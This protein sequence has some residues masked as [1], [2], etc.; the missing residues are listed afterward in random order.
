MEKVV[1]FYGTWLKSQQDFLDTC[2]RCQ[3]EL[4]ENWLKG[5]SNIQMLSLGM[6]TSQGLSQQ[7]SDFYNSWVSMMTN[8]SKI[9]TEGITNFQKTLKTMT[10]KQVEMSKKTS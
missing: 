8:S 10:E 5:I 7:F 4:M 2:F 9:F 3:K 1:E 6:A